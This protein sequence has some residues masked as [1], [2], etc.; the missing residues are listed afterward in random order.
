MPCAAVTETGRAQDACSLTLNIPWTSEFYQISLTDGST[1]S[2]LTARCST[3]PGGVYLPWGYRYATSKDLGYKVTVLI[4]CA[5]PPISVK[6]AP[7]GGT[8]DTSGCVPSKDC[9]ATVTSPS[10]GRY[11]LQDAAG[12]KANFDVSVGQ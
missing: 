1:G 9:Y 2:N 3:C 4:S 7:T 10:G 8:V 5:Q 11:T 12:I 6:S